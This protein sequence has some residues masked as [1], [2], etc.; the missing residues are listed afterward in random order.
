MAYSLQ[1]RSLTDP[2]LGTERTL[3][4]RQVLQRAPLGRSISAFEVSSLPSH[5][6][7]P[8]LKRI[9]IA[10]RSTSSSVELARKAHSRQLR[11][12]YRWRTGKRL[13]HISNRH[14]IRQGILL[15]APS[16]HETLARGFRIDGNNPLLPVTRL[17]TSDCFLLDRGPAL[18][19][20]CR[21]CGVDEAQ[22]EALPCLRRD[23]ARSDSTNLGLYFPTS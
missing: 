20:P 3:P 17:R 18:P 1:P 13:C 21:H 15:S 19:L 10:S 22:R 23:R 9:R 12:Q 2:D 8:F 4:E 7:N 6:L 11:Q 14:A 16:D 5:Q